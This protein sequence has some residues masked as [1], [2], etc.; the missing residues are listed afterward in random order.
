MFG[1]DQHRCIERQHN[2]KSRGQKRANASV[3]FA[4]KARRAW[5]GVVIAQPRCRLSSSVGSEKVTEN[6]RRAV[7]ISPGLVRISVG[8]EAVEDVIK[9]VVDALVASR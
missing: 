5:K 2:L 1:T 3:E 7:G 9:D 6:E 4:R 8:L